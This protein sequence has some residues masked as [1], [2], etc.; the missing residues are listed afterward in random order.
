MCPQFE[1]GAFESSLLPPF[2]G[3]KLLFDE[4]D[5]AVE[6]LQKALEIHVTL[7]LGNSPKAADVYLAYGQAL[8]RGS[9]AWGEE[10]G[11]HVWG[12]GRRAR[13]GGEL[14]QWAVV[15]ILFRGIGA[16]LASTSLSV[17]RSV[18]IETARATKER[19]QG[20][21]SQSFVASYML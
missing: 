2:A 16:S 5:T 1:R 3:R 17:P 21:P 8:V 20:L 14:V 6:L 10:H 9:R 18:K 13:H 4:P 12:G 19:H 11:E 15:E 7:G